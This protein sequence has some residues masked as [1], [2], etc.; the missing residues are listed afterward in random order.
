MTT[1]PFDEREDLPLFERG[2][3][4]RRTDPSTSHDAAELVQVNI[5]ERVVLRTIAS[6]EMTMLEVTG[7]SAHPYGSI[8]PR[9][10]PL[11][12]KGLIEDTGIR[13]PNPG[14]T[15]EAIVWRLT[16]A[17]LRTLGDVSD[18]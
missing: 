13:R 14:S 3:Y 12:Q 4:A 8:T 5:L 17:G 10:R 15:R 7:A 16:A 9:F 18:G 2:A 6:N 11:S 1:S